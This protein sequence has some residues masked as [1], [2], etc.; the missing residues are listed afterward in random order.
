MWNDDD[1]LEVISSW[2]AIDGIMGLVLYAFL[3]FIGLIVTIIYLIYIAIVHRKEIKEAFI[4]VKNKV[5]EIYRKLKEKKGGLAGD[6]S[7]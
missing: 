7:D 4:K 5:V 2:L 6:S 3:A 1:L